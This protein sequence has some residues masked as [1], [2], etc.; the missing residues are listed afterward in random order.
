M[1]LGIENMG[2]VAISV[3]EQGSYCAHYQNWDGK[4]DTDCKHH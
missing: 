2:K 1:I 4:H 3:D